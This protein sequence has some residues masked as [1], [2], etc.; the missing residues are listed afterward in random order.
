MI[1]YVLLVLALTC[2]LALPAQR[3][4]YLKKKQSA[5]RQTIHMYDIIKVKTTRDSVYKGPVLEIASDMIVID[6]AYIKIADITK[7]KTYDIFSKSVGKGLQY[8]SAFFAVIF[9][10]NSL[11]TGVRP[12][13]TDG[14]LYFIGALLVSGIL[15]ELLAARVHRLDKDW[16]VE[17]LNFGDL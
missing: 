9:V 12:L 5:K 3:M 16:T 15:I 11:I 17:V 1:K 7:I 13:L 8:G 2:G 10:A 4:L 14:N 6:N